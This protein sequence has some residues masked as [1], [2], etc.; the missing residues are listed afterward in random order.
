M[1]ATGE[2]PAAAGGAG[3]SP[4]WVDFAGADELRGRR[5]LAVRHGELQLCLLWHAEHDHPVAFDDVCI[6]KQRSLAKGVV[7]NGRLVCPGHQWAYDLVTGYCRERD[8]HQP[9]YRVRVSDGRVL[10]DVSGPVPVDTAAEVTI[11]RS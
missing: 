10:V 5:T 4:D 1:T 3:P 8:R 7:L 6:H 11:D 2:Q 9:T